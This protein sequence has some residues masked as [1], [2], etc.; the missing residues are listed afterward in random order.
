M[1]KV[2]ILIP[3]YNGSE[4]LSD[5]LS[6]V[7]NQTFHHWEVIIGINGH[8]SNSEFFSLVN[9]LIKSFNDNRIKII[10]YSDTPNKPKTLNLM[11]NDC[12][13]NLIA[14]LDADDLWHPQ[15]LELQLPLLDNY[16]VVGTS[17]K[18]FGNASHSPTLPFGNLNDFDFLN[19]NPIINSSVILKKSDAVWN[20]NTILED[21]ELWLNLFYLQK[22]SFF[23]IDK[24]LCFHRIYYKSSFNNINHLYVDE[25][26]NKWKTIINS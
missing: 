11:I 17:C 20:E 16:D 23:N 13:S 9:N 10:H 5:C 22:K 19:Y 4:F 24:I 26:K 8:S 1:I 2:S 6:S 14:I 15:K 25:L 12:S 21:Y 3:L 7:I 18:Y